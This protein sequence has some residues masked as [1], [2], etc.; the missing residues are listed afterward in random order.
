MNQ[1]AKI[2]KHYIILTGFILLFVLNY[3]AFKDSENYSLFNTILILSLLTILY[4]GVTRHRLNYF[5]DSINA[6][7]KPGISLTFDDGPNPEFTEKVLGILKRKNVTASFFIIGK[8]IKGNEALLKKIYTEGHIIGNHSMNHTYWFNS[9]PGNIIAKEIVETE[10]KIEEVIGVKPIFY[11]TPFGLTSPNVARGIKKAKVISIGWNYRSFDTMA[12][13]EKVLLDK[14]I[15]NA[16]TSS[17]IL[18][19]DNNKF[20][21]AVLEAFIDYCITNGIEIVSLDKMIGL[22]AYK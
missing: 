9:L 6:G 22:Q 14:L 2:S 12:K 19:H 1:Q 10:Q 17:I 20:T 21:L 8:N 15:K 18:L 16:K 13:D 3:F 7:L 5:Y 4:I 11:R